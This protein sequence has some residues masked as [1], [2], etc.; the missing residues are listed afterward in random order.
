MAGQ[1]ADALDKAKLVRL[2]KAAEIAFMAIGLAG[3]WLQSVPL[4]LGALFLMGCHSTLFGPVK[5]S[6][7]PQ[8]LGPHEIMGGTG[9]IEAG[10]FLAIL[11]GQLLAGA[12]APW[13]AGLVATFLA[14]VGFVA[15]LFVPSR[16]AGGGRGADRPQSAAQHM[17]GA[18]IGA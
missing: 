16:A 18:Q 11:A 7:L 9:L 4:L 15:S 6:I 12:I 10:T 14:C 2:V 3:F 1:I 5:Y 13:E 8:H 17:D